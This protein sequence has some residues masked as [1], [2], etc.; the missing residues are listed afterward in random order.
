MYFECFLS[1]KNFPHTSTE[2]LTK[3]TAQNKLV[4]FSTG[5]RVMK[6]LYYRSEVAAKRSNPP[7]P[8]RNID[9]VVFASRILPDAIKTPPRSKHFLLCT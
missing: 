6:T 8:E 9:K 5:K 3:L 4:V 1:S 2:L 7:P